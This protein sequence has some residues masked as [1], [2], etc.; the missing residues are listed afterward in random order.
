MMAL[1]FLPSMSYGFE[2]MCDD[3]VD[4]CVEMKMNGEFNFSRLFMGQPLLYQICIND[5]ISR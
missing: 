4:V 2:Y 5:F 3:P 1:D